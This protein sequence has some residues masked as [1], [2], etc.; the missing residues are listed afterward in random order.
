MGAAI[1]ASDKGIDEGG[2]RG[3]DAGAFGGPDAVDEQMDV[4]TSGV[5]DKGLEGNGGE[6][7]GAPSSKAP[8]NPNLPA[9]TSQQNGSFA[10]A[11]ASSPKPKGERL[12]NSAKKPNSSARPPSPLFSFDS[13]MD[14]CAPGGIEGEEDDAGAGLPAHPYVKP[15]PRD[16]LK[17]W[18]DHVSIISNWWAGQGASLAQVVEKLHQSSADWVDDTFMADIAR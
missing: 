14:D 1:E 17:K 10:E 2:E 6:E 11:E 9:E 8:S 15:I 12:L 3:F 16:M 5:M 4:D 18:A 13:F 7:T